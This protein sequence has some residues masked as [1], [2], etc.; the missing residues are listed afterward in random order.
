MGKLVDR[1]IKAKAPGRYSDG[2]GLFLVVSAGGSKAWV[3]RF[4]MAGRRRDMSLG[5]YPQIGLAEVH[6]AAAD[7]RALIA[8]GIDPIDA[9]RAARQAAK[10][11]P[12]FRDI[13]KDV[14]AEEQAKSSNAN[15]RR[16]WA[17]RLGE[18]YC[19]TLLNR[20]VNEI[21]SSDIDRILKPHWT[22]RP[23][24]SKKLRLAL[25]RVFEVARI[26]LRDEHGIIFE[27]PARWDD[28]KAMGYD[29][30]KQLSRG[31]HPSLPYDQM[32]AFISALREEN[33]IAARML[34][35]TILTNV[36]SGA[37]RAATWKE[38]DLDQ[39]LW[40]VPL[41]SLKD[42]DHRVE[43]FRIPLSGPAIDILRDMQQVRISDL[44]FP[45]PRGKV[46]T[47]MAMLKLVE[48]MNAVTERPVW[49]DSADGRPIVPHGFR[50][51][52]KTW[53][54][55]IDNFRAS[56]VEEAMGHAVGNAVERAYKRTDLLELRRKLM[57]AWAE[58]C[59]PKAGNIILF[60][61][62]RA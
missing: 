6:K 18:A 57:N 15:V 61:N 39:A 38:F 49:T 45:S 7:A 58:H 28:L 44:V 23:E 27:N 25:H 1:A 43:A 47:D 26:R 5:A 41:T 8:R 40:V 13:A 36:R 29:P 14:V 3:L 17:H 9:R 56:V 35:F 30:P 10:P 22:K 12:L 19:K 60:P 48:R 34:E 53:T 11:V 59:Q 2:D 24:A 37:A 54:E 21:T 55:E 31:R 52:F 46:F 16:Q 50:A 33:G 62:Q 4:Q 32:P 51:T 42:R 20:P